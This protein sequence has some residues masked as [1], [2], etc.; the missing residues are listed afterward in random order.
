MNLGNP[1]EYT[2]RQLAETAM[3][4][5]GRQVELIRKPLPPDD[6]KRRCPDISKAK[7]VLDFTPTVPLEVGLQKTCDN[8]RSRLEIRGATA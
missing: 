3:K 4:V 8:F 5:A 2:I 7:R 1:E 6:P